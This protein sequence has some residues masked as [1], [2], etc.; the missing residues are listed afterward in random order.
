V[1]DGHAIP[2]PPQFEASFS[3]VS[4]PFDDMPS[5]SACDAVHAIPHTPDPH[6]AVAF[7]AA[8]QTL[9]QLPQ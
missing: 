5:Q 6:V 2:H 1:P 3:G 8:G 9:E 7:G 4:Q